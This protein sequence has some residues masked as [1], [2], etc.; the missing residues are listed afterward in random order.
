ME[1]LIITVAPTGS[2]TPLSKNPNLAITPK[3]IAK[4]VFECYQAGASIAHIHVRE[5]DGSRSMSFEKFKE[6]VER[7]R[8][9]CDIII[10]LTTSGMEF[11]DEIRLKPLTLKPDMA[12][13][14]AG[15]MNFGSGIF[16]N[17]FDFMKKLAK[18]MDENNVKPEIE[19]YDSAMI[20][21]CQFLK[22]EG[23]LKDPLHY[24]FVLGVKGGM[25]AT[26]KNLLFLKEHIEDNATWSAF[27]TGAGSV[28]ISSMA[29]HLGGHTR[30]GM[31]DNIYIKKDVLVERNVE[32]V[33]RIRR[34][35]EEVERPVANVNEAC[36]ILKLRGQG[37]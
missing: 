2:G 21:N 34:M 23:Y 29:I 6:T 5:E 22:E 4:E 20:R 7:I 13:F 1:K 16:I 31:E 10:N 33:D 15:S 30:V 14:N 11:S 8:D 26:A 18:T 9:K 36:K 28:P 27:G 3:Q 19:I 25:A 12:S 24:Q 17:S 35:A 37:V 32:F